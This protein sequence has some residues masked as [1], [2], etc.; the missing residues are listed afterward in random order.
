[1]VRDQALMASGLLNSAMG[2]PPVRPPIPKEAVT[3]NSEGMVQW[4]DSVGI[5]QYRR[6]VYTYVKRA[7]IYPSFLTFD[8]SLHDVSLARRIPTNTPLQ[9]LVTLNDPVYHEAAQSLASRML[10]EFSIA[11]ANSGTDD[12]SLSAA[13][14]YGAGLVLSR[15]P[16][17]EELAALR[18]L[19]TDALQMQTTAANRHV[20]A[21][22]SARGQEKKEIAFTTVA[23]AL[24]NLDAALVR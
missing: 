2:G 18:R 22:T 12:E 5:D 13:L 11:P 20:V 19:Y 7:M 23:T 9:A 17:V 16:N 10:R 8:F 1:M 4:V 21:F 6:A 15:A 24:L 14:T 3:D